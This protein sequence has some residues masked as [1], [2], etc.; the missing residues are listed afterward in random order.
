MFVWQEDRTA[1]MWAAVKGHTEVVKA[2]IDGDADVDAKEKVRRRYSVS[3]G[4]FRND[5]R[6]FGT[7]VRH[8]GA[9]GR[10]CPVHCS[11]GLGHA[12]QLTIFFLLAKYAESFL[13]ESLVLGAQNP[14]PS[15]GPTDDCALLL[16]KCAGNIWIE[17]APSW[18]FRT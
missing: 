6:M 14:K 18:R 16:P 13:T 2:L 10:K 9:T 15:R 7:I 5:R 1:L 4:F 8:L 12:D 11:C 17:I 3:A